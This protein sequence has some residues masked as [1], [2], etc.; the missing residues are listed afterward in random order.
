MDSTDALLQH[1]RI[2]GKVHVDNDDALK[3]QSDSSRIRRQE[4]AA[5]IVLAEA[6]DERLPP[7]SVDS[8]VEQHVIDALL[9]QSPDQQLVHPH[10][11]AEHDDLRTRLLEQFIQQRHQLVRFD[12]EI[13]LVIQQIRTVA[14]HYDFRND[15]AILLVV[16]VLLRCH[17]HER[18]CRAVRSCVNT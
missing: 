6:I 2:P 17:R 12:A 18:F 9:F 16:D 15:L 5:T 7:R 1:G 10:P 3:I 11:L 8:A 13:R 4:R 14:A